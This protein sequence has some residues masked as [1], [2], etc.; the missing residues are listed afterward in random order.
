MYNVYEKT[1]YNENLENDV[2]V[3][4]F[5]N[6]DDALAFIEDNQIDENLYFMV[7]I[8]DQQITITDVN[9]FLVKFLE[10]LSSPQDLATVKE[11]AVY[12]PNELDDRWKMNISLF[13]QYCKMIA[14]IGNWKFI[15]FISWQVNQILL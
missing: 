1:G 5:G 4:S 15:D 12:F 8:M 14:E 10:W 11:L 3:K 6:L 13:R 2:L 7:W 9:V